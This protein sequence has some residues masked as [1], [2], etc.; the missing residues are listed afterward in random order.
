[1]DSIDEQLLNEAAEALLAQRHQKQSVEREVDNIYS[2]LNDLQDINKNNT[3]N[4]DMLITEAEKLCSDN[5]IYTNGY[6]GTNSSILD[7]N[8]DKVYLYRV[9]KLNTLDTVDCADDITWEKYISNIENYATN[10]NITLSKNP[11]EDLMTECEKSDLAKVIK[12]DYSMKI[13]NCDKYDYLIA[14]FCGVAAGFIDSFFV[15]MPTE[16]KLG[17]W[18]DAKV[19]SLVESFAE[20]VWSADIKNGAKFKKPTGIEGAIGYLERRYGIN[21][22]ARY[23]SDLHISDNTF[24]MNTRNHHLKSLGHCPD[25]IGLFFSVLDQF[26]G[27]NSFIS[28]GRILRVQPKGDSFQLMGGNFFAKLFSGFCNWLGHLISDIAGSSGTRDYAKSGRGSGIPVPFYEMLQLCDFGSFMVNGDKKT[29]AEL[30]VKVFESGYDAR[31]G[32]A[33]AIPVVLNEIM[34]RLLW[35]LKSHYYHKNAWSDSMPFGNKPELRRMLL[36]GHGSLCIIDGVD[37]G[38]RSGGDILIFSLHLNTIAWA[39]FAFASLQ[40][41]RALYNKNALD[42]ESID[43]DLQVDWN[44][45]YNEFL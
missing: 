10:N 43:K 38:I 45:L 37:A 1:M 28:D 14:S 7:F 15:G 23:T 12:E 35:G 2:A 4:L 13:A 20:G 39:R 34:I 27:M 26:T 18:T 40:E 24:N 31:H 33:M 19:D 44:R 16:S 25:L 17:N 21:Y 3:D 30:S 41:L 36:V 11:F 6:D 8:E 9:L 42:I 29:I 32:L 22:D 5:G